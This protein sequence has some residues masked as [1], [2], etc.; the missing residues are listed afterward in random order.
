MKALIL[1]DTHP[2]LEQGLQQGGLFL[3]REYQAPLEEI[4]RSHADTEV[5]IIRSRMKVDR[6]FLNQFPML[7]VIGRLGAGLENIDVHAA[8]QRG[9][10]CLRVPEGNARAVA[11]HALGMLLS[12]LNHLPRA[13]NQIQ[14]G[15][16]LREPNKGRELQSL[17]V[18]VI[19]YGVMGSEF[20]K[21]L[22]VLG[23][24]VLAYDKYKSG[25][26]QNR[27]EEVTLKTIQLQADVVSLHLPLN[28]ETKGWVDENFFSAFSNPIHFINTARGPIVKTSALLE[29]LDSGKVVSASLDVLEYEKTS[30]TSLNE[31]QTPNE[32]KHLFERDNVLLT[33]HIAGWTKESFEKMGQSLALK[34]LNAL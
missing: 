5:L 17:V 13:H 28:E 2:F 25:Y 19:G 9:I 34:V 3:V 1:D 33:P 22:S 11:E 4:S 20:A 24:R 26:A 7:K 10:T 32:L 27:I 15:L 18:G 31:G 23:V 6:N 16:W 30:F 29:A 21:L 12:L 8:E 14:K